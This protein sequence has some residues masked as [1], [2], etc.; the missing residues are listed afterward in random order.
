MVEPSATRHFVAGVWGN[1]RKS[2]GSTYAGTWP[3]GIGRCRA[4]LGSQSAQQRG[5]TGPSWF[6]ANISGQLFCNETNAHEQR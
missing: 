2:L 5:R 4:L 1:Q 6:V 3:T